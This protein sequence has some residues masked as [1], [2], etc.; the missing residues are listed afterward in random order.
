MKY[1][2]L[3]LEKRY[4]ISALIKAGLNQKSIAIE[5]GMHPSTISREFKRN[6]DV[7]RGYNAEFAHVQSVKVERKKKRCFAL[8]KT[9]EK[10]IRANLKQD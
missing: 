1:R 3:T 2:Q 4:Q 10:Y 5:L 7:C 6:S 9:I 8:S